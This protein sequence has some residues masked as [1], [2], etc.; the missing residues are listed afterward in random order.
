MKRVLIT[1]S[2]GFTGRHLAKEL[3]RHHWEV[4]GIGHQPSPGN[5]NYR[6]VDLTNESS[7][8]DAIEEI[9][10]EGVVHLAAKAFVGH[11][12]PNDFYRVNLLGTRHLLGALAEATRQPECVVLASSANIYG[13]ATGGSLSEST[14][15][16]PQNDYAVSKLAMEFMA[17]LWKGRLPLV[18]ARPFNYTGIGQSESFLPAKIVAHFRRRAPEIELGNLNV[19]RD[20]SDVRDVTKAYRLLLEA[21]PVGAVVNI[22]SGRSISLHEL[23]DICSG[24]TR[25]NINVRINPAFVRTG[26]IATLCGNPDQLHS[27]A[28]NWE[29]IPLKDTLQWMLDAPE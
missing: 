22:C 19:A 24:V 4:W 18:I 23:I 17:Q 20:F 14:P 15:P 1:G 6:K 8:R 16:A 5:Q 21:C 25:H 2:E 9:R 11:G 12:N 10:P 13:N 3:A 27:L 28:G 7:V 29:R 26:E